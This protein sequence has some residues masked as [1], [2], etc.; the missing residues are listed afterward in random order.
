MS[1]D[2]CLQHLTHHYSRRAQRTPSFNR[3]WFC[4]WKLVYLMMLLVRILANVF[5]VLDWT[6]CSYHSLSKACRC[7][8]VLWNLP[9]EALFLNCMYHLYVL[10]TNYL[11]YTS[12]KIYGLFLSVLHFKHSW[13]SSTLIFKIMFLYIL[14]KTLWK[15][16]VLSSFYRKCVDTFSS[17]FLV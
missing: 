17:F 3:R 15:G 13:Q 11:I 2:A 4:R 8:T 9:S 16:N 10:L 12:H 5:H 14:Y 1:S 7:C 6:H